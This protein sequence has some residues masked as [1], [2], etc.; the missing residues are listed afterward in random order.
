[1]NFALTNGA[2]KE[3]CERC[4]NHDIEKV[5]ELFETTDMI[6]RLN[7]MEWFICILSKWGTKKATGSF[8]GALTMDDVDLMDITEIG[9]LFNE[10]MKVFGN[11]A[12]PS[13]DVK[14]AKKTKAAPK[15]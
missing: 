3:L 4:P 11:D 9:E 12:K 15:S 10:A 14:S 2:V 7:N 5:A 1:M 8:D 6:E 13:S